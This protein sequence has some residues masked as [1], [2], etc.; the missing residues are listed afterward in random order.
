[1][2]EVAVNAVLATDAKA[3][4]IELLAQLADVAKSDCVANND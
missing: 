3:A 1:L 2:L 4:E